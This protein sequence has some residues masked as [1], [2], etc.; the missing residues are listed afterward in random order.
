[1]MGDINVCVDEVKKKR[2]YFV[3]VLFCLLCMIELM[4]LKCISETITTTTT[5]KINNKDAIVLITS[6]EMKSR[7]AAVGIMEEKRLKK[8]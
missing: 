8:I 5:T 1:M 2:K 4:K 7:S 3:C 6:S